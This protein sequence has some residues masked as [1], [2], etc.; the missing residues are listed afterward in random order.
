MGTRSGFGKSARSIVKHDPRSRSAPVGCS[1]WLREGLGI[2]TRGSYLESARARTARFIEPPE[3]RDRGKRVTDCLEGEPD[4]PYGEERSML[5]RSGLLSVV[6]AAVCTTAALADEDGARLSEVP[7][8]G[9]VID[10]S[11]DCDI[12][13][14]TA[15]TSG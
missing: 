5:Q 7:G 1:A 4:A 14:L 3:S 11:G 6:M 2:N 8:W 15:R 13:A 12:A 9:R 10:P